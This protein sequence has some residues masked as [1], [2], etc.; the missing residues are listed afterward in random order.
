MALFVSSAALAQDK[1]PD[2]PDLNMSDS[3]PIPD[4]QMAKIPALPVSDT[5]APAQK[6]E[7]KKREILDNAINQ[8]FSEPGNDP[9]KSEQKP[10][11][12]AAKTELNEDA[13]KVDE[14][15]DPLLS[16]TEPVKQDNSASDTPANPSTINN[17]N[18]TE[19]SVNIGASETSDNISNTN[20]TEKKDAAK[21][22]LSNS[23]NVE[24]AKI[25]PDKKIVSDATHK[26]VRK[27]TVP[28]QTPK[29]LRQDY[30]QPNFDYPNQQQ[31]PPQPRIAPE[32]YPPGTY[33]VNKNDQGNKEDLADSAVPVDN[34]IKLDDEFA[35]LKELPSP[36]KVL[37]IKNDITI[38]KSHFVDP[39]SSQSTEKKNSD[40]G[41]SSESL[42]DLDTNSNAPTSTGVEDIDGDTISTK[43]DTNVESEVGK[44]KNFY[45]QEKGLKVE[46][47]DTPIDT[48]DISK[49]AY[50][51]LRVGQY[52]SAIKYYQQVL[53]YNP[54]NIKAIFGIATA[55]QLIKDY[56]NAKEQY[57]KIIK[58]DQNFTAAIN[59]YIILVANED[60]EKSVKK[61]QELYRYNPGYPAIPAQ[62]G[63]IYFKQ[64]DLRKSAE[65][66]FAA[67][68]LAPENIDYKY[69][70]A[71]ILDNSNE[72]SDAA[73][74]YKMLLDEA[75][76][77]EKLPAD[78]NLIR[79]RFFE[80]VSKAKG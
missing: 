66:Y 57:L 76:K 48:L 15:A 47:K 67:L 64:G 31:M 61:L 58:I 77:G 45:Q 18:V 69:N 27:I 39:F 70:L 52:E 51:A 78:V 7:S 75:A 2:L 9:A 60:P 49:N 42:S 80:M 50:E 1:V 4:D 73:N 41:D 12:T 13:P 35:M 65:L 25:V 6:D 46:V 38:D 8:V 59:N 68:K 26:K 54:E 21:A 33:P 37:D 28:K 16:A 63:S 34:D 17:G 72:Y 30:V 55:Y 23:D 53:E 56:E 43:T 20:S 74:F 36:K 11:A 24:P 19:K 10:E 14:A 40:E 79:D 32:G 62:L 3:Q 71:V 44:S 29:S 5:A 22:D